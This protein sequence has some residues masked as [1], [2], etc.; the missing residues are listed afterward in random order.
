MK[1][2][3]KETIS[4]VIADIKERIDGMTDDDSYEEASV[5]VEDA[6]IDGSIDQSLAGVFQSA[7]DTASDADA[8][9]RKLESFDFEKEA[10]AAFVED[11]R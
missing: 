7:I 2:L 8:M 11:Q 5:I 9:L 6:F 4:S 3:A 1:A 10:V